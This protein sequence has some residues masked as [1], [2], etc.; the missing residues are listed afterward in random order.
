MYCFDCTLNIEY[1]FAVD[2]IPSSEGG[3]PVD[4]D[5]ANCG[6][7]TVI[8]CLVESHSERD[9]REGNAG[10][11][12]DG[13]LQSN[14]KENNPLKEEKSFTFEVSPSV[15]LSEEETGKGWKSFPSVQACKITTVYLFLTLI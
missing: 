2:P 9:E 14:S 6:S 4:L 1:D 10:P 11:T 8:S 13:K 3:T 5:K 7:P 15:V 12:V